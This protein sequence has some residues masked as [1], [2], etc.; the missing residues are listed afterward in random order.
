MVLAPRTVQNIP[1]R[2]SRPN[3]VLQPLRFRKRKGCGVYCYAELRSRATAY[4]DSSLDDL[5]IL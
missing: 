2:F 3:T 1:D 4:P 5:L